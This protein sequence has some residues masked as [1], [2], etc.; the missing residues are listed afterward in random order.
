[1]PVNLSDIKNG[2]VVLTSEADLFLSP[3]RY[4][5]SSHC[6]HDIAI[7][8]CVQ[9]TPPE[10]VRLEVVGLEEDLLGNPATEDPKISATVAAR[11]V[12]P[13][14]DFEICLFQKSRPKKPRVTSIDHMDDPGRSTGWESIVYHDFAIASIEVQAY[15]VFAVLRYGRTCCFRIVWMKY[16]AQDLGMASLSSGHTGAQ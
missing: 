13:T 10:S 8:E 4:L 7:G 16:G 11:K 5:A 14:T 9:C 6:D 15:D 12:I 1:M 2:I 3:R